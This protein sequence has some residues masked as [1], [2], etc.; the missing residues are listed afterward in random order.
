MSSLRHAQLGV[1]AGL[2]FI[3]A[4]LLG[5]SEPGRMLAEGDFLQLQSLAL[6]AAGLLVASGLLVLLSSQ[7]GP[8]RRRILGSMLSLAGAALAFEG[9]R[10]L[11]TFW[12]LWGRGLLIEPGI[13]TYAAGAFLW[14]VAGI[15]A[16]MEGS[17]TLLPGKDPGRAVV[18]LGGIGLVTVPVLP[19]VLLTGDG[20]ASLLFNDLT[21]PIFS[22]FPLQ[23]T[24]RWAMWTIAGGL[25]WTALAGRFTQPWIGDRPL[26]RRLAVSVGPLAVLAGHGVYI[27][28]VLGLRD[29]LRVGQAYPAFNALPLILTVLSA[30]SLWR[31]RPRSPA[32]GAADPRPVTFRAQDPKGE[33]A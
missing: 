30:W 3:P 9:A 31:P 21:D 27:W 32:T 20:Q 26:A 29:A 23:Q 2:A 11:S 19:W 33:Q 1:A 16:L 25:A 13:L 12:L 28:Q 5:A 14:L 17:R 6:P 8:K 10:V 15:L 4:A 7:L 18:L 24:L 22:G